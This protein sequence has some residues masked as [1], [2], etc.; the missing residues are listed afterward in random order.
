MRLAALITVHQYPDLAARLIDSLLNAKIDVFVHVDA[1][2]T[3]V[4]DQLLKQY[5]TNEKVVILK[6]RYKVFWGS[7]NQVLATLELLREAS[8][9]NEYEYYSFLSG[10]DLPIKPL[11]EFE[12]FLTVNKGK[13]FVHWYKLPHHENHGASGGMDRLEYYWLNADPRFK[14]LFARL[15]DL[16]QKMQRVF[17]TKRKLNFELY[18]GSNWFTLSHKAV[19]YC[20]D[21]LEKDPTYLK[22]FKF[23]RCADEIFFQ[24]LLLN[25][26]LKENIVNDNL[27]YVDWKSGPEYPKVLR[28]EDHSALVNSPG[29]FFGR[30]F[31]AHVDAQ[32]V[33][34]FLPKS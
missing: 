4:H 30:K 19:K 18:A 20:L 24:T 29:K 2:A 26:P 27:R 25:S 16:M 33:E 14:K 1:R 15:T 5:G 7:F 9:K 28:M 10:Q 8:K 11:G 3:E 17:G 32:I 6:K 12:A 31:D 34:K 13:E 22:R 21:S 23:T